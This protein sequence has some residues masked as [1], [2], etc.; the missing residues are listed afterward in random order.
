MMTNKELKIEQYYSIQPTKYSIIERLQID[1]EVS[2]E[3]HLYQLSLV[4]TL[5]TTDDSDANR[6]VLSFSKVRELH[7]SPG[8]SALQL[9][10]LNIVHVDGQWED[11]N[12]KVS[13]SEQDIE[14]SFLCDDF[15]ATVV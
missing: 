11:V 1:Q 10:F 7:L 5:R 15:T 13:E 14:F 4:I 6:L 2:Y 12:Y 8:I 3:N 9:S